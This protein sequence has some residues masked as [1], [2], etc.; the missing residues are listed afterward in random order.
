MQGIGGVEQRFLVFLVVLVVGQRLALHQGQ[1]A[2][3]GA[4][5]PAGLAAY[6][7]RHVGVLLLRHDRGAGAEAVGQVDELELRAGPQHQLFRE[8]RQVHHRQ[9]GGG[10]EFDGEVAVGDAVQG[11]T[12]NRVEAQQLAGDLALDRVG[13]AGQGRRAERHAVDPLAAVDQALV[14]AAE[15]LEPGQQVVAE[16]H[17]LGGLQVGETGHDGVGFRFGQAQQAL[18][19]AGD[20]GEDGVD[21]VA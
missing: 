1:Q 17:R 3:E 7:L 10:A 20:L 5:H 6:Q 18:L 21:L 2:G 15:H 16:G 13:G 14:V 9:A 12:A 19:Q 4:E 8:A 11:V